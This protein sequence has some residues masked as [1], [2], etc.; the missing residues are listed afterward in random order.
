M[1]QYEH[2][3]IYRDA[4]NFLIFCETVVRNFSRYNKYTHG[5]ELRNQAKTVI[6]LI[7]RANNSRIKTPMLEELRISLEE[8]K[9]TVRLCKEIKAFQNFKQFENAVNQVTNI[10][11]QAEGWLKHSRKKESSPNQIPDDKR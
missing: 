2:L 8:V 7:V 11:R 4:Y 5:S 6:N 10:S 3:P 9:L 1:A